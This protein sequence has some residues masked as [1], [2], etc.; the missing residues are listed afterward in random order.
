MEQIDDKSLKRKQERWEYLLTKVFIDV[1]MEH[2]HP[3]KPFIT[4][5][6]YD[7]IDG[8]AEYQ[9]IPV[10]YLNKAIGNF[11]KSY[12]HAGRL[13]K[14]PSY[15]ISR[16]TSRPLVEYVPVNQVCQ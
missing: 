16:R 7:K 11:L 5:A 12:C 1:M 3:P 4:D 14:L 8:S 10:F 15:A 13:K 6:L 2:M 9:A